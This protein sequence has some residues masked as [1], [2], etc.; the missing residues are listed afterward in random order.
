MRMRAAVEARYPERE[1]HL[2]ESERSGSIPTSILKVLQESDAKRKE[3]N[4]KEEADSKRIKKDTFVFFMKASDSVTTPWPSSSLGN[5]DSDD[6][7]PGICKTLGIQLN[8]QVVTTQ[9]SLFG[10]ISLKRNTNL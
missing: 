9:N 7:P 4:E 1:A 5:Q 3:Q 8:I 2:A 10:R 6:R